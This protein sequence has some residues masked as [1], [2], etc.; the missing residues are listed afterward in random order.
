MKDKRF[1]PEKRHRLDNPERRKD[2]P[3]ERLL[4]KMNITKGDTLLE[5]GAGTGYFSVAATEYVGKTG[6]VMASDISELML[7][8]IKEQI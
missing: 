7:A 2:F 1:N 6:K 4:D 5:I 8:D 3:P